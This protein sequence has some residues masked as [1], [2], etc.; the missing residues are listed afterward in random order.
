MSIEFGN[1]SKPTKGVVLFTNKEEAESKTG[2]FSVSSLMITSELA[3]IILNYINK[4]KLTTWLG[5]NKAQTCYNTFTL[6]FTLKRYD[7]KDK[8]RSYLSKPGAW[9][10]YNSQL[11]TRRVR[12]NPGHPGSYVAVHPPSDQIVADFEELSDRSPTLEQMYFWISRKYPQGI[13]WM[14]YATE[15]FFGPDDGDDVVF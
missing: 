12:V 2:Y 9:G 11:K 1:S 4:E 14:Q 10:N 5:S 8:P 3:D 13:L 6:N 7:N 15:S